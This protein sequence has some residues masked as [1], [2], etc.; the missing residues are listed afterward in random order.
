MKT[1]LLKMKTKPVLSGGFS[2][3]WSLFVLHFSVVL[4]LLPLVLEAG[5]WRLWRR[6]STPVL[7]SALSFDGL[8]LRLLCSWFQILSPSVLRWRNKDD[9]GA[10]PRLCV[11]PLLFSPLSFFRSQSPASSASFLL[12]SFWESPLFVTL[13]FIIFLSLFLL[14]FFCVPS[15]WVLFFLLWFFCVPTT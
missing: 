14:W 4:G 1:L 10:A 8:S 13:F 2:F 5:C 6:W 15:P 12:P 9:G 7:V 11:V 3:F